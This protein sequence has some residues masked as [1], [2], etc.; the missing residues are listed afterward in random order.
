MVISLGLLLI[1]V[2]NMGLSHKHDV[3]RY[4]KAF[5]NVTSIPAV[6]LFVTISQLVQGKTLAKA[7][8]IGQFVK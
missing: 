2:L 5:I 8:K 4:S 1:P 3:V 6:K 7:I